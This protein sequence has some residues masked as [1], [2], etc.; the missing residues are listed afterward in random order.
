MFRGYL[1]RFLRERSD[2]VPTGTKRYGSYGNEA[3]RFLRERRDTVP[4]GMKRYGFIRER[5]GMI[6]SRTVWYGPS[7]TNAKWIAYEIKLFEKTSRELNMRQRRWLELLKDYD[8]EIIYH[9]GKANMVA[10]A[11]SRKD[12]PTP[13]RVK[14]CQLVVT[15]DVMRDIERAQDEA[16]KEKT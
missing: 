11:L 8:Y 15:S 3:I 6:H 2:A 1:L 16:L 9:P 12:V 5:D 4:S 7:R 13:I 14:A 10:V